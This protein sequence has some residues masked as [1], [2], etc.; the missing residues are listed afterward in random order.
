MSSDSWTSEDLLATEPPFGMRAE[1]NARERMW[2]GPDGL[3]AFNLVK[4]REELQRES[5]LAASRMGRGET[6]STGAGLQPL[7]GNS[8]LMLRRL[9]K[10]RDKA[11]TVPVWCAQCGDDS[12]WVVTEHRDDSGR[13]TH[14]TS[15]RCDCLKRKI[16]SQKEKARRG[17]PA[18]P[19]SGAL[20]D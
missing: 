13:Q 12:G 7:V 9:S 20:P 19:R 3:R 6:G 14:V 4:I 18:A 1:W 2:S 15:R 5:R 10:I 17:K 11:D 8:D 16:A